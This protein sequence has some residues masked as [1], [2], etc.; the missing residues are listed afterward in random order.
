MNKNI[1]ITQCDNCEA[2]LERRNWQMKKNKH[3]FCNKECR[4]KWQSIRMS[5]ENNPAYTGA[6][7]EHICKNCNI[8]FYRRKGQGTCDTCSDQC[9]T[10]YFRGENHIRTGK[11]F[12]NEQKN[13]RVVNCDY[14]GKESMKQPNQLRGDHIFCNHKCKG[15]FFKGKNS[16]HWKGGLSSLITKIRSFTEYIKWRKAVFERDEYICQKCGYDKGH[17]IEAHHIV[18]V[19]DIIR[20]HNL[21]EVNDA[22]ECYDLWDINNGITLCK[23]CHKKEHKG[24]TSC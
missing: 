7:V 22:Y 11:T 2:D 6:V 18:R 4:A 12:P 8:K 5:G 3:N 23:E 20:K 10:D 21:K 17:I 13:G 19:T 1:H 15:E 14:C 16:P 9:R 24:G